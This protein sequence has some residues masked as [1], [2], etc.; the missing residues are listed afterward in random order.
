[1]RSQPY[2]SSLSSLSVDGGVI[3]LMDIVIE[4]LFP[5]AFTNGDRNIRESPWNEEEEKRRQDKWKVCITY[6]GRH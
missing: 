6:V 4:R 3:T 5:I 1:M 2:I